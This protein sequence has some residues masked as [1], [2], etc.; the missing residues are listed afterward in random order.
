MSLKVKEILEIGMRSLENVGISDALNDSKMLLCYLVHI[1]KGRLVLHYQEELQDSQC[2]AYFQLV[3]K[4]ATGYP[5]QYITGTQNFMGYDFLVNESVL[6][7]R[8]DTET[9][10]EK[11]AEILLKMKSPE[12]L[13][14]CTGSGAI[15]LSL[16]K[17]NENIKLTCS[18][19]SEDALSVARKNADSIVGKGKVKFVSGNLLQPFK[20]AIGKKKFDLIVSNPPY[21]RSDVI[22]TL[23]KEV[24]DHEPMIALDGGLD[25]LD[26]YRIIVN[27]SCDY[28]KESGYLVLEIGHDQKQQLLSLMEEAGFFVEIE[29]FQDLAGNDRVVVGKYSKKQKKA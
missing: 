19:I 26:F 11:T 5:L 17:M 6:I 21:I 10:V 13:D 7:P 29:S 20:K 14:L 24:K 15:G 25:G 23:D 28:L 2:E 18:D 1:D 12:V 27:S 4:R 9:L 22:A 8:Q 16:L 3:E